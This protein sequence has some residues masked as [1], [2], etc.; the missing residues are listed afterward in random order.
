MFAF[1]DEDLSEQQ[2]T[3]DQE[4]ASQKSQS[5]KEVPT[6]DPPLHTKPKDSK[7]IYDASQQ[8]SVLSDNQHEDVNKDGE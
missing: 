5:E 8:G 2:D 6:E 3:L 1:P 4:N 7:D